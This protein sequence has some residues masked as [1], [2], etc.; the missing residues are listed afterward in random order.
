MA[1]STGRGGSRYCAGSTC[2]QGLHPGVL[3][4]WPQPSRYLD[5]KPNAPSEIRGSFQ[6]ISTSVPGL[7]ICEHLPH[8]SKWMHKVGIIR[9]VHH[10]ATLHDSASIHAL[11]GRPLE[12]P[13]REL[14]APLPQFY[15]SFGSTVAWLAAIK[16]VMYPSLRYLMSFRRGANPVSRWRYVR[17]GFRSAVYRCRLAQPE[18][19]HRS[20]SVSARA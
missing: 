16:S 1:S 8:M 9:S 10:Q 20:V 2:D 5:M 14:F 13:D 15:P 7:R 11:T 17:R 6:S 3:L 19:S 12:G 18:L 4:R